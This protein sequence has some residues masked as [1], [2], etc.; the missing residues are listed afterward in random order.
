MFWKKINN[1]DEKMNKYW[2]FW[3]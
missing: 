3:Y 2:Y 1:I